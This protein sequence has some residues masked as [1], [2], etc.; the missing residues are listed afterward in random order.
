MGARP[1]YGHHL[2][3][4]V[5]LVTSAARY[6]RNTSCLA[7]ARTRRVL[8]GF[9]PMSEKPK[10][11]RAA[12]VEDPGR[13]FARMVKDKPFRKVLNHFSNVAG[14]LVVPIFCRLQES[15]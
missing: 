3:N 13:K 7:I 11:C 10:L 2:P 6:R 12:L 8:F 1:Q 5:P 9:A 4:E 14:G 15:F